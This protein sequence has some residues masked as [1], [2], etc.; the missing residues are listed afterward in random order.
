MGRA[1]LRFASVPLLLLLLLRAERP[2]GAE[3]TFELPDSARQCFH[4]DV[5]RGVR[6]ALDYQVGRGPPGRARPGGHGGCRDGVP[7]ARPGRRGPPLVS[8]TRAPSRAAWTAVP[9][10]VLNKRQRE[11]V[12]SRFDSPPP[13]SV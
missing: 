7:G 8:R 9:P 2:Q 1:A 5:G 3:L 6:F 11:E 13:S 10:R 4:E 12:G